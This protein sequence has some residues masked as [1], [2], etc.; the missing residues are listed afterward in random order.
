V[1]RD[2]VV[3][4]GGLIGLGV[5][6]RA[7][8]RGLDVCV[9]DESGGRGAS[10]A[11][12]GL[13]APVTEAHF[14]EES[15]LALNLESARRYPSFVAEL[16]EAS[17]ED[18]GYRA[19]GT[20][21]VA[22]DDDD[23]DAL[24][25]VVEWQQ[26][27]GLD[28]ERLSRRELRTLEPALAPG[29]RAGWH[30]ASDHEVDNRKL[31]LALRAACVNRGVEVVAGRVAEV[32]ARSGRVSGVRLE[33][34]SEIETETVVVA[35]GCWSGSL[36]G[37]PAEVELPV[38]PV[39]GQLL[40][41]KDPSGT[42]P[43]DRNVRGAD[44]YLVSRGDGRVVIGATVEERGFDTTITG[45]AVYELLRYA[46]RLVPGLGEMHLIETVSGLR[47]GTPDNAPLI[48]PTAL[49]GLVVAAGH[50]RNGVLL[51]PVTADAIAEFLAEGKLP[52]VAAPFSPRRFE[53]EA[54]AR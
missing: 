51:T 37:V 17:G 10:W 43:I 2:A 25:A 52:D 40:Y 35:G 27:L 3:V 45:G 5:A 44:V 34:S 50:Y 1:S 53:R 20:V 13:L 32:M 12:A 22:A 47:P 8:S 33:D 4:G 46:L 29:M 48:G 19:N 21:M 36:G 31:L 39:K 28:V 14:G 38:R 41:L 30:A 54:A 6:W 26:R 24:S 23:L 42:S 9:V 49:D 16:E 11:A 7:A 15:L 18:A